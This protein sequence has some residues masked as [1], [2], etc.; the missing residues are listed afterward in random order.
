MVKG[1]NVIKTLE[2]TNQDIAI[3][4]RS[5][6]QVSYTIEAKLLKAIN[7][8]PLKRKL[9]EFINCNNTF[10]GYYVNETL[11]A[12]IEIK[13]DDKTTHIQSL[14]VHPY[15]FRKGF[16][17]KLINFIFE[18]YNSTMFTVETGA[19]NLPAC[20]LY[21][22]TGFT[23]TKKWMTEHDIIKVHYKKLTTS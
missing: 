21:E 9:D 15:F 16:A 7:F 2:H 11:A 22:K 5:I 4:I 19:A 14:V 8:P 18:T 20:K 13:Q 10:Y 6:F 17:Q 1:N 3:A 12:V 23:Q